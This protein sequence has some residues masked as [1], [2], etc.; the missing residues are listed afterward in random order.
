MCYTLPLMSV[1]DDVVC[2]VVCVAPS[3]VVA[4]YSAMCVTQICCYT[5]LWG[6][7]CK[8][9]QRGVVRKNAA[10]VAVCSAACVTQVCC[11]LVACSTRCVTQVCCCCSMFN[12]MC[13]ISVLLLFQCVLP[14]AA[15]VWPPVGEPAPVLW[16]GGLLEGLPS[17]GSNGQH[18]WPAGRPRFLPGHHWPDGWTAQGQSRVTASG[19][20]D[21][22]CGVKRSGKVGSA[23]DLSLK[24]PEF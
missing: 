22:Y 10:A 9:V 17:V 14:G 16:A 8:C 24:N 19:Q 2:S 3:S 13:Y 11:R 5:F 18:P 21:A 15:G 7:L 6:V 20:W 4:V 23:S 12:R 1:R